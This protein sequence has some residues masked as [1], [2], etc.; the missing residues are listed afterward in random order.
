MVKLKSAFRA[1]SLTFALPRVTIRRKSGVPGYG[2]RPQ[3][4]FIVWDTLYE[5]FGKFAQNNI[6]FNF[7]DITII[8]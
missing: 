8:N 3:I 5:A 1:N 7:C 4:T 2:K 6:W